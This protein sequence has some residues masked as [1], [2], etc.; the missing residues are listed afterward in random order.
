MIYTNL[1]HTVQ[2][3]MEKFGELME[4]FEGAGGVDYSGIE[5][6]RNQRW[7]T[8]THIFQMPF[9]Y[10]EYG[11]AQVAAIGIYRN[12]KKNKD[13]ALEQFKTLLKMGYSKP[14]PEIFKAG[15][16]P[17]D[18]SSEYIGELMEFLKSELRA[19]GIDYI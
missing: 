3:R 10:I 16:I 6:E 7:F 18:F 8:Q 11:I 2:Q 5:K 12:Y 17:F 19:I 14:L 15:G 4:R 13:K 1:D 9:Y